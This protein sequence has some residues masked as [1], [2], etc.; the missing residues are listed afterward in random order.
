MG[1]REGWNV[2]K[3]PSQEQMEFE[4]RKKNFHFRRHI[5]KTQKRQR[6][7][8]VA[9]SQA[10]SGGKKQSMKILNKQKK[11][12]CGGKRRGGKS[13]LETAYC[14]VRRGG[15]KKIA[16]G[17]MQHQKGLKFKKKEP[18]MTRRFSLKRGQEGR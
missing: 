1:E 7:S 12:P 4:R 17:I 10:F 8:S 18:A 16:R 13:V 9:F 2:S 5:K 11:S 6:G 15:E 14:C 3:S